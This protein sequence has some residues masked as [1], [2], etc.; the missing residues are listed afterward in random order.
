[1]VR[2]PG[3]VGDS[4][5]HRESQEDVQVKVERGEQASSDL[6][7][8]MMPLNES[9]SADQQNVLEGKD[10]QKLVMELARCG[11]T[12]DEILQIVLNI[13]DA[14]AAAASSSALAVPVDKE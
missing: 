9:R 3:S 6:G 1:M 13:F 7:S 2:V 5:F 8:T 10:R 4:G 11:K 12:P 14:P